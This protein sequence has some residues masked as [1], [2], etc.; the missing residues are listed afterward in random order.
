M[1]KTIKF[2]SRNAREF[3]T[4]IK[5]YPNDLGFIVPLRADFMVEKVN[6]TQKINWI[7]HEPIFNI[8]PNDEAPRGYAKISLR[9][10][11]TWTPKTPLGYSCFITQPMIENPILKIQSKIVDTDKL[12]AGVLFDLW[13]K[14]DFEGIVEKGTPLAQIIPFK[15][16]S[17][18][19]KY[20]K[21]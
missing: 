14:E 11:N 18:N 8:Y 13:I 9:Y 17:W 15:R 10:L 12:H 19:Q 2:E 7:T 21:G 5:P 20:I 4:Y 6:G 1:R 3:V 16:N